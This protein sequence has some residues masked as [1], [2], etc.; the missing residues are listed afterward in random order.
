M[1]QVEKMMGAGI[2]LMAFDGKIP[3]ILG[4]I[5]DHEYRKKHNA[6]YDLP[7]GAKDLGESALD[8]ALRETFE[9]TGID[10]LESELIAGPIVDSFL[11]MW[12]AEIPISTS[13]SIGKNPISGKFE[14]DGYRWLN[15]QEAMKD[16]YPYLVPF[17][18][19]AFQNT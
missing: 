7:K 17:V 15:E 11:T 3:M 5:G 16:V 4:L 8:C 18:K 12:L 9:E 13:I 6:I 14:H 2:I 1:V 19:W 10:I